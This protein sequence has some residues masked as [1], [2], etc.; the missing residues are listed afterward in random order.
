M[1]TALSTLL[2]AGAA[3]AAPLAIPHF[4][5]CDPRW[6]ADV[7]GTRGNASDDSTICRVGCAMTSLAMLLA[8]LEV[9]TATVRPLAGS[10][11]PGSLNAWLR[12][13]GGYDCVDIR[14]DDPVCFN[15]VSAAVRRLTPKV[16]FQGYV[17][18]APALSQM[19]AAL[20]PRNADQNPLSSEKAYLA[21][22]HDSHHFVLV[23]GVTDNGVRVLDPFFNTSFYPYA[24]VSGA[25]VFLLHTADHVDDNTTEFVPFTYPTFKQCDGRWGADVIETTTVCKVGCLMSST[26][27]ALAGH[28]IDVAG[29]GADP[30]S[31]NTWLRTHKGYTPMNDFEESAIDAVS[32]LLPPGAV[33]WP[34]DGMHSKN[35]LNWTV[36]KEYLAAQPPRVVI[37]NV[38]HGHH[39]VLTVGLS[40]DGDTILVNDPGF[41]KTNYSYSK[42]VVGWRIFDMT[43]SG[44]GSN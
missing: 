20:R 23:T 4:E 18:P 5:Q 33:T 1:L 6:G 30:G 13:N 22:V 28:G 32:S 36:L 14:P 29:K 12:R 27:M 10:L 25:L 37:A 39:F 43:T 17:S 16:T 21:H 9:P 19:A 26:S 40:G 15:L 24:N 44:V 11:D 2:V 38:L 35:D 41:D 31:L 42:D 7:I 8:G 34:K 3:S